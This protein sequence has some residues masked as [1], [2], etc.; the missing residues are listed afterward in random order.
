MCNRDLILLFFI[1]FFSSCKKDKQEYPVEPVIEFIS[2]TPAVVTE[3]SSLNI[4]FSY[5][6]GDGDLGENKADI[7]NLFI[8]DNRIGITYAYRIKQLAPGNEALPIRGNLEAKIANAV[9]TNSS[10]EQFVNFSI[11]ITDRAGHQ[12]N[13]IETG[14]VL[15][16]K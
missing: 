13:T 16:K 9:I 6:D 11:Y 3:F 12:S 5:T 15:I 7:K 14:S 2:I 10:A 8:T 4:I 1:F